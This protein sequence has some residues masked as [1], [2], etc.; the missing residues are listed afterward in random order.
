MPLA[1]LA[2]VHITQE[3]AIARAKILADLT[4]RPQWVV[5]HRHQLFVVTETKPD[6][7]VWR[8]RVLPRQTIVETP[9]RWE[10]F[11]E[12]DT[13]SQGTMLNRGRLKFVRGN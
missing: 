7:P 12:L 2:N 9:T 1:D 8:Y 11:A 13:V 6:S 4:G 5:R 3:R 10:Q